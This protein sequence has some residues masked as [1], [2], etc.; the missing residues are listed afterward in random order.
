MECFASVQHCKNHFHAALPGFWL[1]RGL[2]AVGNCV[3]VRLAER[4]E[5]CVRFLVP[6]DCRQ[7]I[8]GKSCFAEGII[9]GCPTAVFFRSIDLSLARSLHPARLDQPFRVPGVDLGP[10]TLW[11]SWSESLPPREIIVAL[12]LAVD[13]SMAERF[14]ERFGV[15]D[16]GFSRVLLENTQPNPIGLAMIRRQPLTKV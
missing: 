6:A 15:G 14:I 8:F 13:P 3:A 16:G 1:L 2:E 7:K 5:E 10:A 11:P 12:L 4:L 9:G